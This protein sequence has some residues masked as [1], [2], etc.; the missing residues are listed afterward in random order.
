MGGGGLFFSESFQSVVNVICLERGRRCHR[1][2]SEKQVCIRGMD[3]AATTTSV[4]SIVQ[5]TLRISVRAA[6]SNINHP[7]CH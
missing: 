5:D 3:L 6:A 7:R 4:R 1:F 2:V